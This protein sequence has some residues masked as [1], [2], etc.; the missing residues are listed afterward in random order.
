[1]S[2]PIRKDGLVSLADDA[3]HV[4]ELFEG[5]TAIWG[6]PVITAIGVKASADARK[7][8]TA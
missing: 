5:A 7:G 6:L 3:G 2:D 1:L 8:S 4:P